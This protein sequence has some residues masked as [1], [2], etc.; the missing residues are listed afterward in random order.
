[1]RSAEIARETRETSI[2]LELELD[3]EG[4]ANI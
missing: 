4:D 1:M 3:G 2:S